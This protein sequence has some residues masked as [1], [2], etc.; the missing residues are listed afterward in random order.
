M[1]WC[2]VMYCIVLYCVDW[3][4][5]VVWVGCMTDGGWGKNLSLA[6]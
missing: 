1:V 4:G 2:N 5:W 6:I 3:I